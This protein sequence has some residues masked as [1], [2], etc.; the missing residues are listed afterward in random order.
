MAPCNPPLLLGDRPDGTMLLPTTPL[1]LKHNHIP[2][3]GLSSRRQHEP[4]RPPTRPIYSQQILPPALIGWTILLDGIRNIPLDVARGED[5]FHLAKGAGRP[6]PDSIATGG[7]SRPSGSSI[8]LTLSPRHGI[9]KGNPSTLAPTPQVH[10]L[11]NSV[12]ED[13]RLR[14]GSGP[15]R[16]RRPLSLRSTP[17]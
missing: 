3:Q 14:H 13:D 2:A 5:A 4:I 16:G 15:L 7:R 6:R 11:K 8:R 9:G 10:Q 17:A 12:R 1:S